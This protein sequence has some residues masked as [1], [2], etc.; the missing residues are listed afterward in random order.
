MVLVPYCS[1]IWRRKRNDEDGVESEYACVGHYIP[2]GVLDMT[3]VTISVITS[4]EK[5]KKTQRTLKIYHYEQNKERI[6]QKSAIPWL[7]LILQ[8]SMIIKILPQA[9]NQIATE[10]SKFYSKHET[11]C[12]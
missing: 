9:H 11:R 3:T 8:T 7:S 10:L 1:Q 2:A 5:E 4:T 12:N 6:L